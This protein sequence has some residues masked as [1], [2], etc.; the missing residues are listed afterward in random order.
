MPEIRPSRDYQA[1]ARAL[2]EHPSVLAT[3]LS[4]RLGEPDTRVV[5]VVIEPGVGRVP[6]GVLRTIA[7][8]DFGIVDVSPQGRPRQ[9]IVEVV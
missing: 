2:I 1:V 6:P 8:R 9:L 4:T 7:G 3:D 5:R